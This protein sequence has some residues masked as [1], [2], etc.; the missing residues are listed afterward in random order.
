[1]SGLRRGSG[2]GAGLGGGDEGRLGDAGDGDG[3]GGLGIG[4]EGLG[5]GA[6]GGSGEGLGGL[7]W[8]R[9]RI[10]YTA[11]MS[12]TQD[13]RIRLHSMAMDLSLFICPE[14]FTR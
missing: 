6:E 2:V 13:A 12:R 4:G 10:G 1:M 11:F 3:D 7:Q 9:S 8:A 5:K 14:L